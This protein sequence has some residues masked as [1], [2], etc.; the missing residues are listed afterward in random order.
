[1]VGIKAVLGVTLNPYDLEVASFE[2]KDGVV[3][4]HWP[5]EQ[6][7]SLISRELM[8]QITEELNELRALKAQGSSLHDYY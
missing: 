7:E 3:I 4:L 5:G 2:D 8:E 1:M 6:R